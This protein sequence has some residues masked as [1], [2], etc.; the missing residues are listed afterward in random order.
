MLDS[1]VVDQRVRRDARSDADAECDTAQ[2]GLSARAANEENADPD[3]A[4]AGGL[5]GGR[6]RSERGD[7]DDQ[8]EDGRNPTR[9]W[10]DERKLGPRVRGGQ[11]H[12]VRE[13]E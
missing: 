1:A 9:E 6:S 13:L 5:G 10:V 4:D 12:D 3:E 2:V 8:D 7:A 11:Q